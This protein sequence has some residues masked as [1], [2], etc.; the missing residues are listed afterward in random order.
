MIGHDYP[1]VYF[2]SFVRLAV[3]QIFLKK[4]NIHFASK[5]VNPL[6]DG[7]RD[8]VSALLIIDTICMRH[9]LR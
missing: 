7:K 6:M 8:K 2:K 4:I 1:C 9:D 3:T 5:H